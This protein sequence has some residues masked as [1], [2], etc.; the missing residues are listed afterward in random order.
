MQTDKSNCSKAVQANLNAKNVKS[1]TDLCTS[2]RQ[3][4]II[5][6]KPPAADINNVARGLLHHVHLVPSLSST[7]SSSSVHK[8]IFYTLYYLSSASHGLFV[9]CSSAIPR[10]RFE[11]TLTVRM[12][13]AP[14]ASAHVGLLSVSFFSKYHMSIA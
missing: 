8:C 5:G 4:V 6:Y 2:T 10:L 7:T 1:N 3:V 13:L 14:I 9:L 11:I 12:S